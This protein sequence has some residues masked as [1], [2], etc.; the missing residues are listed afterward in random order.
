MKF[1]NNKIGEGNPAYIIAEMSA[2]HGGNMQT[3]KDIIKAAKDSGADCIKIQTYTADTMT[4]DSDNEYFQIHGGLWDGY[5]LYDLY[6]DAYTPW[7]WQKEL[8]D[9][10]DEIGMDFLS[11]PFDKTSVDFLE[12]LV[13]RHIRLQV[14]N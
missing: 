2:N 6:E 14:L 9:Y 13:L 12:Q 11:T 4:I 1:I 3:A 10:A 8:K 7:E 5:K